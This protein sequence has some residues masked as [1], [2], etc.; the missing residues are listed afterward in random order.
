LP[1]RGAGALAFATAVAA[2][3]TA[4]AGGG[5]ATDAYD[6][7]RESVPVDVGGLLD[8]HVQHDFDRPRSGAV[9]LR[10]FDVK[11]DVP[12]LNFARLTVARRPGDFGFRL[13]VGVGDT[14]D[15]YLRADPAAS[16][17]PGLSRAL[18]YV[19]QAFVTARLPGDA[20]V[21]IDV[22]RFGTPVGLEDNESPRNY[23]ASRSLLYTWAE[24]TSHV[25]ARLTASVTPALAV[26]AFW[27]NGWNTQV[28]EGN[29]MRS[30]AVAASWQ[31]AT[32]LDVSATYLAGRDRA[33]QRLADPTEA[34]RHVIDAFAT[35][36]PSDD[37]SLA[38]T[39][40][41]GHDAAAGG[42]W[43]WGIA[44]YIQCRPR[45]WLAGTLRGEHYA[46]PDGFTTGTA[47]RVA[48]VTGTVE[49]RRELPD[50]TLVVR[51][52][53]RR[54]KSTAPVFEASTASGSARSQDTL[55]L[56]LVAEF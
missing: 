14:P 31:L 41:Y 54:D 6:D 30:F 18:S 25:G 42:V 7:V 3:G 40:D 22:G 39:A 2:A 46:D 48:A 16:T 38:L 13:D 52:E 9:G 32:K 10:A 20:A 43:W 35:F 8:G 36:S 1:R 28:V 21:A 17:H 33:P 5:A 49:I 26:S 27:L 44:G 45:P 11:S 56:Q 19:E 47:Q 15:G 12:S 24:P 34:W 4:S 29:G 50:V 23:N 37:V 53:Y 51:L 55:A